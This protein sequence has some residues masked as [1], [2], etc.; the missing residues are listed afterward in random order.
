[1]QHHHL[2]FKRHRQ[3]LGTGH[4]PEPDRIAE[5]R[6]D[7]DK[8]VPFSVSFCGCSVLASSV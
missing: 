7:V 4:L 6:G 1:M 3:R 5:R 8:G 2:E